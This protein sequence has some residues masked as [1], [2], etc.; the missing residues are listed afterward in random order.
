[1]GMQFNLERIR[2]QFQGTDSKR[3]ARKNWNPISNQ[4]LPLSFYILHKRYCR[5]PAN[6]IIYLDQLCTLGRH[7]IRDLHLSFSA[8]PPTLI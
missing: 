1:M 5:W 4:H 6:K 7:A 3:V 8:T 2:Q